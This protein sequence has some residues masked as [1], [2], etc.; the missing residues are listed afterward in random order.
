MRLT[1]P[2]SARRLVGTGRFEL[3]D[4][5]AQRT[6]RSLFSCAAR[7]A[8]A[9]DWGARGRPYEPVPGAAQDLKEKLVGTGRF[10]LPTPR[11]PSGGSM[12]SQVYHSLP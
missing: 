8:A 7:S 9:H 10:E 11:T 12:F 6:P 1:L 4:A 2:N 5:A 3:R